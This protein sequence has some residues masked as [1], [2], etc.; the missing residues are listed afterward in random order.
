MTVAFSTPNP[1]AMRLRELLAPWAILPDDCNPQIT[2]LHLDS[3]DVQPGGLF[4]ARQGGHWHSAQFIPQAIAQGAEAILVEQDTQEITWPTPSCPCI[5]L[6]QVSQRLGFL[7]ARFYGNPSAQ[8]SITGITGTNGKTTVA[9]LLTHAWTGHKPTAVVGTLGNGVLGNLHKTPF[10]T[11]Q[12]PELQQQLAAFVAAGITQVQMEVSSHALDQGRVNGIHFDSAIFTNLTHDHLDYHGTLDRYGQAKSRL[13]TWPGLAH[14]V[15]NLDDPFATT[16][17]RL[18]QAPTHIHTYAMMP[19]S[20]AT[21]RVSSIAYHADGLRLDIA[22]TWGSGSLESRLLGGFNAANLAAA[23]T[24]LNAQGWA[25]EDALAALQQAPPVRGRLEVL[26][27]KGHP[28][29]VI[30]YAHTPDGLEQALRALRAHFPGYTLHCVFGCGGNRDRDKRPRMGAIA[31]RGADAII[32][33]N[34][35]PR[36]ENPADIVAAIAQGMIN[37]QRAQVILDRQTAIETAYRQAGARSVILVAGKGHEEI[38]QVG[39]EQYPFSDHRVVE[40]C[41]G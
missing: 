2:S 41:L 27:R 20:S 33:T 25:W 39:N 8:L 19:Q 38:Q 3:R 5:A 32:L 29:F 7:A 4:I 9:H 1:L 14:A 23:L 13:F 17:L 28:L 22:S 11:P 35:N 6:P 37:P 40:Q 15:I 12:A 36:H 26:R 21:C 16:L 18:I 30:D 24:T 31:E 34:D 10:T